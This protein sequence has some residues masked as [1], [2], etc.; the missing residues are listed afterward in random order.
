MAMTPFPSMPLLC[1]QHWTVVSSRTAQVCIQP[2]LM[3]TTRP[4]RPGTATGVV[5]QESGDEPLPQVSD[6]G[7]RV[8]RAGFH[9]ALHGAA[10]Q[11]AAGMEGAVGDADEPAGLEHRAGVAPRGRERRCLPVG[12]G[13]VCRRDGH[14]GRRRHRVAGG[15]D[16]RRARR[17]LVVG[18]VHRRGD[19]IASHRGLRRAGPSD[20][21]VDW[22]RA[23]RGRE[24][25][26]GVGLPQAADGHLRDRLVDDHRDRAG[27]RDVVGEVVRGE[28]HAL[29]V[30]ANRTERCRRR[31]P[32]EGAGYRRR[33]E[34]RRGRSAGQRGDRER[35]PVGNRARS[36]RGHRGRRLQHVDR[37]G[38][39]NLVESHGV[40]RCVNDFRIVGAR[41][42]DGRRRRP[43]DCA[44]S[45]AHRLQYGPHARQR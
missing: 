11:Q 36:W 32:G 14:G 19:R 21:Q 15:D 2:A 8:D 27:D 33:A 5:E 23:R 18:L 37:H 10:G 26:P 35:L 20:L 24:R 31:I 12:D 4:V 43:G 45:P 30:A 9:P 1:P 25:R 41:R 22:I 17:T 44:S 39:V 3:D 7:H 38:A 40:G 13:G 42:E 16:E 29:G 34:R 6:S 28:G